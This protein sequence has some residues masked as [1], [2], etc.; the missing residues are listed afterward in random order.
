MRDV[1]LQGIQAC[2][3]SRLLQALDKAGNGCLEY[4]LRVKVFEKLTKNIFGTNCH[5]TTISN[6]VNK[7]AS[8]KFL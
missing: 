1:H 3:R 4:A 6:I 2:S 8:R 7:K 5:L